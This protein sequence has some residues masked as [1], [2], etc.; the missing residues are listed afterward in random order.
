MHGFI[1]RTRD[2][3][4]L[5]DEYDRVRDT[6][7]GSL[8]LL[9]GRR[10]IGKSW[11]AEQ[12]SEEVGAPTLYFLADRLRTAFQ[13]RRFAD[14]L[15]ASGL[16]GAPAASGVTYD[17]WESALVAAAAGANQENPPI[18]VIDE[19]PY[20]VASEAG[21]VVEASV[22]AAWERTL[23]RQPVMVVLI[24][25]DFSI[26]EMLSEHDR[27]LF[28]RPTM[29]RTIL[30]LDVAEMARISGLAG[31]EAIDAYHVVGGFPRLARLWRPGW[32]LAQFL[33]HELADGDSPLIATG[34][35]ILDAEFPA[36]I[37]ARTVFSVIGAG[38]R[39]YGNIA[40][41]AGIGST[42]L[43][44]SLAQ[45]EHEKYVIRSDRPLSTAKSDETRYAIADPYLRFYIRFLDPARSDLLRGRAASVIA[46]ISRDWQGYIGIAVEPFIRDSLERIDPTAL[47]GATRIGSYWTR[48]NVPQVDLVGM[49]DAGPPT[50]RFMGSVKW[51]DNDPFSRSD[52]N[53]LLTMAVPDA[54]GKDGVPGVTTTTPMV[55][56]SRSGFADDHGLALALGPDDLLA[57]WQ[58]D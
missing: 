14:S 22:N 26:M 47:F 51:R 53:E 5:H 46:R 34:R 58:G 10:R 16:P 24:G 31:T 17:S 35:R 1:G 33:R 48:S 2:L 27:P 43:K 7:K 11:L 39:T 25:S 15:A 36:R 45:L 38:E 12:F 4:A 21:K 42:N 23:S 6:G 18:I 28:D 20:A 44:R 54:T 13:L 37:E 32:T 8:V 57:A 56:V 9:K 41:T 3:K 40:K 49:D 29:T 55:G 52:T 50:V 19:F 30:P